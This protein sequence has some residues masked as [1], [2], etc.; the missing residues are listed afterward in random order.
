MMGEQEFALIATLSLIPSCTSALITLV[1]QMGPANACVMGAP[2]SN[3]QPTDR[4]PSRMPRP[5][6]LG[7]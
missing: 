3:L 5:L 7:V 2:A 6:L 4:E 1:S